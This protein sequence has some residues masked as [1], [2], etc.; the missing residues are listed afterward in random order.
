MSSPVSVNLKIFPPID[1]ANSWKLAKSFS[2]WALACKVI[3]SH[4][5]EIDILSRYLRNELDF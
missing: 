4:L 1:F 2:V 3:Q 5:G